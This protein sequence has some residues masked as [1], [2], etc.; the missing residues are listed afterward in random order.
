MKTRRE[1]WPQIVRQ[2]LSG[3][4]AECSERVLPRVPLPRVCPD[5]AQLRLTV[6]H[7]EVCDG[8]SHATVL[9]EQRHRVERRVPDVV[10]RERDADGYALTPRAPLRQRAGFS[11]LPL[12][13]GLRDQQALITV[14]EVAPAVENDVARRLVG[15]LAGGEHLALVELR[16]RGVADDEAGVLYVK[17]EHE[18]GKLV[19]AGEE[20]CLDGKHATVV[21]AH[22]RHATVRA[23]S[24]GLRFLVFGPKILLRLG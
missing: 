19:D 14:G 17:R 4:R 18:L 2:L 13:M 16:G 21:Q 7:W 5:C 9:L 8:P 24:S 6:Q 23:W 10:E 20:G 15:V 11:S 22:N 12:G 1:H 3:A